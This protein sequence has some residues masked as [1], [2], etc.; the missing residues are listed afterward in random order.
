MENKRFVLWYRVSTSK[1]G[2]DGNGI[3]AQQ[4][5]IQRYLASLNQSYEVL[6]EFTE[7]R[8]G[9]DS[10]RSSKLTEAL[11]LCRK[12]DAVLL[13]SKLDRLSR[14]A[15]FLLQLQESKTKFICADF[16]E[17]NEL[18][19][20]LLAIIASYERR[21]ISERTKASLA[22]VRKTK[23]LGNPRIAEARS[24]AMDAVQERKALFVQSAIKAIREI[25]STAIDMSYERIAECMSMRGI[26]TSR[27]N[28]SKWTGTAVRRV[29]MT[30]ENCNRMAA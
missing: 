21:M 2:F 8:T 27:G 12:H 26:P 11:E 1:Q 9:K 4:A 30:T 17:A 14:Q 16:P 7:V 18:T 28:G 6:G 22:I 13:V 5:S 29:L 20:S 25:Q 10:A 19:I 23:T 24:K 3:Q 15:S